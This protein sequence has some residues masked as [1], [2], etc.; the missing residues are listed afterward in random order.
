[1]LTEKKPITIWVDGCFDMMHAGHSNALRQAKL[2]GDILIVGVHSDA[3]ILYNK[4]P[5]VMNEKERYEAVRACKWVDKVVENA[6]YFTTVEL[7]KENDCDFCVHGDDITTLADGTD[8]YQAVKD[9]G[10]YKECKRTE[11]VSTTDIVGRMLLMSKEH[12]RKGPVNKKD[13]LEQFIAQFRNNKPIRPTDKV[14]YVDGGFD[15]FHVGHVQFL[16]KVK[17]E[18]DY[19]IVGIHD[20][21]VV[22][23]VKGSNYPIMTLKERAMGVLACRYVDDIVLGAPYSVD[24]EVLSQFHHV[25]YVYHGS[26]TIDGD[27]NGENPYEYPISKGIFRVLESPLPDLQTDGIIN[28][29]I[30]N[31]KLYEERNRRKEGK[32]KV[33][34]EMERI[35]KS[36]K[37]Y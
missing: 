4:G 1:M 36:E 31:R 6:P 12:L 25:D 37:K 18:C 32:A 13:P 16:K 34:L 14:V 5:T 17:K 24:K 21:L 15:L 27:V 20:D 2:M 9:A 11:G 23:K 26:T 35:E 33:E 10:L 3:E 19:L 8:C 28:R 30:E 7:L 22:N 29:I